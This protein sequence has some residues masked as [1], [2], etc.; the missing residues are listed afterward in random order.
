MPFFRSCSSYSSDEEEES[1]GS[2]DLSAA[3]DEHLPDE[4]TVRTEEARDRAFHARFALHKG[5]PQET[6]SKACARR[7]GSPQDEVPSIS[8]TG[9]EYRIAP[10]RGALRL[11]ADV[12]KDPQQDCNA[13]QRKSKTQEDLINSAT[14]ENKN[15]SLKNA[16]QDS[17]ADKQARPPSSRRPATCNAA[18]RT[19]V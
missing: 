12:D 19:A 1:E 4:Q 2:V 16:P 5:R 8:L 11:A 10:V 14:D 9:K 6:L 15:Y 17:E 7:Q 13:L 18:L 3:A